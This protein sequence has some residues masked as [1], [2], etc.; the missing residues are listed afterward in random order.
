VRGPYGG[1]AAGRYYGGR[2][3]G[4]PA[5]GTAAIGAYARPYAAYPGW[6]FHGTYGLAPGLLAASSLAFLS[7]G[8]LVGTYAAEEQTV[9]VYVV[10]EDGVSMEYRVDEQGQVLSKRPVSEPE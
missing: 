10:E 3:Y 9:Y 8:L 2:Y 1:R 5:W 6:R 7:T 4:R